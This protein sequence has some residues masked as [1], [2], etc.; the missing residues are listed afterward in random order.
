MKNKLL[1]AGSII[2]NDK[3]EVLLLHRN[4]PNRIQW[5]T[6]GGKVE[7]EETPEE[8]TLRESK[9][10]L[11]VDVKIIKKLG[12]R[13][14]KEDQYEMVYIWFLV[15]ILEGNPKA[16]EDKHDDLCYW[17]WQDLKNKQDLSPNTQNL[18]NAYFKNELNIEG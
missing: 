6:P 3:S 18:V 17:S 10:E 9:E 16:I 7:D 13:E 14:F 1:L 5:E 8:C 15:K 2:I 4:A 11:G 12:Q